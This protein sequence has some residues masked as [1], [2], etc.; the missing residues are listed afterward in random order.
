VSFCVI[1]SIIKPAA[2][3]VTLSDQSFEVSATVNTASPPAIPADAATDILDPS[4][5][6]IVDPYFSVTTDRVIVCV[7][8]SV[9]LD[10]PVVQEGTPFA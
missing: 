8:F 3:V 5:V 4:Q 6:F 1:F 7:V 2:L 9:L 10:V